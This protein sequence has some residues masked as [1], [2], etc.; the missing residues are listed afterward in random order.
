MV[1]S[2]LVGGLVA[3]VGEGGGDEL[4]SKLVEVGVVVG[5][6]CDFVGGVA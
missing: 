4:P 6:E 3:H 5:G 1:T 2:D